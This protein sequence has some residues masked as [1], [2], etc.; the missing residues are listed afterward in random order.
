MRERVAWVLNKLSNLASKPR[1]LIEHFVS[2]RLQSP[3]GELVVCPE[4]MKRIADLRKLPVRANLDAQLLLQIANWDGRANGLATLE[5]CQQLLLQHKRR[6]SANVTLLTANDIALGEALAPAVLGRERLWVAPPTFP[7][8][9][10]SASE[11]AWVTYT[12]RQTPVARAARGQDAPLTHDMTIS[13]PGCND[14][15]TVQFYIPKVHHT[16]FE[17][18]KTQR[19]PLG[20]LTLAAPIF[21]CTY[22]RADRAL[23]DYTTTM[24]HRQP[25]DK[26]DGPRD[27]TTKL[28]CH[29]WSV[30][31]LKSELNRLN[32]PRSDCI[33]QTDLSARLRQHFVNHPK[34]SSTPPASVDYVQIV[35]V[36]GD[37]NEL[38][39]QLQE[40]GGTHIV[41]ALPDTFTLGPKHNKHGHGPLKLQADSSGIGYARLL[42]SLVARYGLHL[43]YAWMLDDNVYRVYASELV[44]G[45]STSKP[46]RVSP[47]PL[48][49]VLLKVEQLIARNDAY[50]RD[51]LTERE[52]H[53]LAEAAAATTS[54]RSDVAVIGLC[55]D[56]RIFFRDQGLSSHKRTH[57]Y[58]ACLHHLAACLPRDAEVHK[59]LLVPPKRMAEDVDFNHQCHAAGKLVLKYNTFVLLKK[60]L[61]HKPVDLLAPAKVKREDAPQCFAP[62]PLWEWAEGDSIVLDESKTTDSHPPDEQ[63]IQV[64]MQALAQLHYTGSRTQQVWTHT[65]PVLLD[66]TVQVICNTG[67]LGTIACLASLWAAR[68]AAN[69]DSPHSLAVLACVG[70]VVGP[71]SRVHHL[72][73]GP[74]LVATRETAPHFCDHLII[75]VKGTEPLEASARGVTPACLC[76]IDLA[77]RPAAAGASSTQVNGRAT[78]IAPSAVAAV[79][80]RKRGR[81]QSSAVD[82]SASIEQQGR[83]EKKKKHTTDAVSVRPVKEDGEKQQ[84]GTRSTAASSLAGSKKAQQ[85]LQHGGMVAPAVSVDEKLNEPGSESD[86]DYSEENSSEE[87]V[88]SDEDHDEDEES[89]DEEKS[90][91]RLVPILNATKTE[92]RQ[93]NIAVTQL[94]KLCALLKVAR[95]EGG[96]LKSWKDTGLSKRSIKAIR[97]RFKLQ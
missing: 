81:S 16:A 33:T 74:M 12:S 23:L 76:A 78:V 62:I 43:D 46:L 83:H 71:V 66:D 15:L 47:C 69:P 6:G 40:W 44:T 26:D 25:A 38:H 20:P 60:N 91:S 59:L 7:P 4:G 94:R 32:I 19:R 5:V 80:I 36:R 95:E 73:T 88:S 75:S 92:L 14:R 27:G 54:P 64:R 35:V 2:E 31:Q 41:M 77:Y 50:V 48:G 86:S 56:F 84:E 22:N 85:R 24:V 21:N 70:A 87:S 97:T 8:V 39:R 65:R 63:Q 61:T 29:A 28:D 34:T 90:S 37:K 89:S 1:E 67:N 17:Q 55:R 11:L 57:V 9:A 42:T 96:K 10:L 82:G 30:S 51:W 58:A 68:S 49:E 13:V 3:A 93:T 18:L 53:S 72:I 45:P 79:Q 52:R